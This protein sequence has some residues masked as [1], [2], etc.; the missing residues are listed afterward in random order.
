[1]IFVEIFIY[2][3]SCILYIEVGNNVPSRLVTNLKQLISLGYLFNNILTTAVNK[4][5]T[6]QHS[7]NA[8]HIGSMCLTNLMTKIFLTTSTQLVMYLKIISFSY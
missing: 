2:L 5:K 8:P 3:F 1:M 4:C 6:I 7:P